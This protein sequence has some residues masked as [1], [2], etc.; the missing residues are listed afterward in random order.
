MQ[1]DVLARIARM[2]DHARE[3][4]RS[5]SAEAAA[6]SARRHARE[7]GRES[8]RKRRER[9]EDDELPMRRRRKERYAVVGED[10]GWARGSEGEMEVG[11]RSGASAA[12]SAGR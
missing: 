10:E 2:R 6:P 11:M 5:A 7:R 12:T 4:K 1:R 9:S 3:R 8:E